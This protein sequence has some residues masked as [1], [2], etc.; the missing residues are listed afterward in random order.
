[1]WNTT[2]YDFGDAKKGT[3]VIAEFEYQGDKK[4]TEIKAGCGC[5]LVDYKEGS[6]VIKAT[7]D[8]P[9]IASHLK[10][11]QTKQQIVKNL[12]IT[13]SDGTTQVL[14]IKGFIIKS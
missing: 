10:D 1:M 14:Y 2:T 13:F 3:V 7:Y 8:V 9:A 11:T 6:N 5:T 4:I 12:T